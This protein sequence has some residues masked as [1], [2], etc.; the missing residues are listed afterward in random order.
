LAL[1]STP[2][3]DCHEKMNPVVR[4]CLSRIFRAEINMDRTTDLIRNWTQH[5]GEPGAMIGRV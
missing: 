3:H 4:G 5:P 1:H 2:D